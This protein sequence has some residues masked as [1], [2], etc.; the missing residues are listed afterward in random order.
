M[1]TFLPYDKNPV[2]TIGHRCMIFPTSLQCRGVE[3]E[4]RNEEGD[5]TSA[6]NS[7]VSCTGSLSMMGSS[8]VLMLSIIYYRG[9]GYG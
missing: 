1:T 8:V 5:W 6:S 2:V 3:E 7:S 4:A 9:F